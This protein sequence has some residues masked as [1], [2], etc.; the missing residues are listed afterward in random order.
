MYLHVN[1]ALFSEAQATVTQRV[2]RGFRNFTYLSALSWLSPLKPLTINDLVGFVWWHFPSFLGMEYP[3]Y[4][5]CAFPCIQSIHL[6]DVFYHTFCSITICFIVVCDISSSQSSNVFL[7]LFPFTFST[8][9]GHN[10]LGHSW[11]VSSLSLYQ[12]WSNT[13]TFLID[14]FGSSFTFVEFDYDNIVVSVCLSLVKD[15]ALTNIIIN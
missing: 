5:F 10:G 11:F 12:K 6:S 3:C 14:S 7:Q 9:Y 1:L 4:D 15:L 13:R 8:Y 2:V